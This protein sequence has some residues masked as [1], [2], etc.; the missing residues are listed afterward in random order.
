MNQRLITILDALRNGKDIITPE[1]VNDINNISVNYIQG[2]GKVEPRD[3]RNILEIS[4]ILYNNT[5]RSILP[6]DDAIYDSV[7]VKFKNQGFE[8]PVGAVGITIDSKDNVGSLLEDQSLLEVF[9]TIP[10]EKAKDMLYDKDLMRFE[11]PIK[12]DFYNPNSVGNYTELSKIKHSAEHNYP[13]LVGTL[14]KCKYTTMNEAVAA[15]VEPDDITTMV[16]ERDF[17]SRYYNAVFPYTPDG[18]IGLIAELKYDGVSIEA[19][20]DGDTIIA[21]YS[22]GDT[23]NG[24]ASDYTPIFGGKVFHRAKG[25]IPKGTVFGIKFEAIVTDRNLEI[26][27]Y[28]FGKEYKNSRV[29]IIGLLGSSDVNKYRDLI[30]LVPIR[31]SGLQ[32]DDMVQEVEFL[33]KYYSS[34]VEMKYTYMRGNYNELLFQTYRFVQDAS[35]LRGI[36]GFMYDGVVISFADYNIHKILGRNNFTDNW[37]MA[38]KFNAMSADTIFNGYT[39]TVGQN[40]LITP[41]AHFKPVQFLGS[42]HD[43][44]TAHSYKR[45]KELALKV[46]DP[47][48][49]TYVNDVI[50]YIDKP[51]KDVDNPNPV[52]PFPTHCPACGSPITLSMSGDSAYC[53][54]PLCPER[55]ATRITNMIKKL[56]FKDFSRAYIS[57]LD[58][59]SFRDLI[60][61]DKMYSAEL[62]G[63]ALT[64]KLFDQI[65][66]IKSEPLPDY[67]VVGALGFSSISAERWRIILNN[68]SLNAIIHNDDDSVRRLIS[69]VKGIGKV[70]ADTIAKE[71]HAFMDD[72][73]LIESMPNLQITF[74]G[75]GASVQDRK[76]VR[77]TGFRSSVLE[78]EFNK[79][80]FDADGNKSVTKKTDIL[81]IPYPGFVS[82]KLSKISPNCL[83]L[84]EKDAYDYIMYL[85]S[86]NNL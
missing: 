56:G 19:T 24:I 23:A 35:A 25:I 50:C 2:Q 10:E 32:F 4:N 57:K 14:Y 37:A 58:I 1:D 66:K 16:F 77:F 49:I 55:N 36:M 40:G 11:M 51:F 85:Q 28:K 63:D 13:E 41:M 84:S 60:E 20:V 61:L 76:T 69:M 3:I 30:T 59:K 31:T 27:K 53:L 83:V 71:R 43:K 73:L 68:V 6:L 46:G 5:Q 39:Y 38:I 42:T 17:L 34:G 52:I 78:E 79:L 45:F 64:N 48:R 47:V 72:L 86:Q 18:N 65:N 67:K 29:A 75:E 12:E 15:G 9:K 44:T 7:V 62:I 82:S 22:R 33:N 8:P 21:A 26:L 54:N 74:R 81:V 80:G 70:I